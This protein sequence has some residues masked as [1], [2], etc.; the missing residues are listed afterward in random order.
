M[1]DEL[2]TMADPDPIDSGAS[3]FDRR[4]A[5]KYGSM[6]MGAAVAAPTLLT[7]AASPASASGTVSSQNGGSSSTAVNSLSVNYTTSNTGYLVITFCWMGP[8]AVTS[9]PSGW[10]LLASSTMQTTTAPAITTATYSRA[11]TGSSVSIDLAW[12]GNSPTAPSTGVSGGAG[13]SPSSV[14][15]LGYTRYAWAGTYFSKS[16]AGIIATGLGSIT[17]TT[18]PTSGSAV[19]TGVVHPVYAGLL[20]TCAFAQTASGTPAYT[21]PTGYTIKANESYYTYDTV[22]NSQNT[23]NFTKRFGAGGCGI[24][25]SIKAFVP[26]GTYSVAGALSVAT[27]S[28]AN[29]IAVK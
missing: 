21:K 29:L 16:T 20:Y 27:N 4:R 18:T 26:N 13:P 11:I 10:T 25:H 22:T 17:S 24:A 15:A 23:T 19:V 5:L 2:N 28:V 3:H 12:T 7:L 1:N 14:G 9:T 6:A 8:V